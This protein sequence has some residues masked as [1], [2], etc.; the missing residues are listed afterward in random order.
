MNDLFPLW[1][2][3]L[4]FAYYDIFGQVIDKLATMTEQLLIWQES[5][6]TT[7]KRKGSKLVAIRKICRYF[8]TPFHL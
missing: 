7:Q 1:E 2:T 6:S 4:L 5:V 3:D 8:S